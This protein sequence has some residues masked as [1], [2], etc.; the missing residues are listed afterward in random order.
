MKLKLAFGGEYHE[1]KLLTMENFR[2][3]NLIIAK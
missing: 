3:V 1:S 2:Q